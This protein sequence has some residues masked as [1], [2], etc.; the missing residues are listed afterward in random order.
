[1]IDT[2]THLYLFDEFEQGRA[3]VERAIDAKVDTMIFP[4]VD[5]ES[6]DNLVAMHKLYPHNTHIAMGL[7]PTS[8]DASWRSK[9]QSIE[10]YIAK[11]NIKPVA[12]GEVGIDLYWD[13][14]F[15]DAQKEAF[16][17]QIDM[18]NTLNLPLIIHCRN[19]LDLAAAALKGKDTRG[20]F[21]SFTGCIEDVKKIRSCGDFYFGINGVITYKNAAE[22]RES[23]PQI[24]LSRILLETDSPY[25]APHP[26]RGKRNESSYLQ[27]IVAKISEVLNVKEEDVIATTTQ[28]ARMLFSI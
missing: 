26:M 13:T 23:L 21:H 5:G 12:I 20:V 22:L 27:Y 17:F 15:A 4:A 8:V 6:I 2:H 10:S 28:N 16:T 14:T 1:M 7:H 9:L 19:G 18:A 3:A 24:G 25:L 11:E